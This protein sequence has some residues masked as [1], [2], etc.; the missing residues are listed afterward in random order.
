MRTIKRLIFSLIILAVLAAVGV[1]WFVSTGAGAARIAKGIE[2]KTGYKAQV[3]SASLTFGMN[4]VMS[5]LVLWSK[6]ADNTTNVLLE[7]PEVK[8]FRCGK[9]RRRHVRLV[10][11]VLTA[12]KSNLGNWTPSCAYEFEKGGQIDWIATKIA[13]NNSLTFEIV[14]ASVFFRDERGKAIKTFSGFNWARYAVPLK[15]HRQMMF[16]ALSFKFMDN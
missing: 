3:S 10:R 5:D 11:P 16:N 14:D 13:D 12:T 4:L 9:F 8:I 7:V 15:K 1:R 2:R 6:S